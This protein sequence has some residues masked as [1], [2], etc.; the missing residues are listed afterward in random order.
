MIYKL[1][2]LRIKPDHSSRVLPGIGTTAKHCFYAEFNTAGEK[3]VDVHNPDIAEIKV[4]GY[5][6]VGNN[7]YDMTK[8]SEIEDIIDMTENSLTF[9]TT[10][11]IYKLEILDEK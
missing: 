7:I 3:V 5:L 1:Q 11:S 9:E 2:K 4:G 6:L 8:T 10:T